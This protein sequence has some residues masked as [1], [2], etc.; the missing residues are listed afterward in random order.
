[1]AD[2]FAYH[3]G[4]A[5]HPAELPHSAGSLFILF[6]HEALKAFFDPSEISRLALARR[7]QRLKEVRRA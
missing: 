2:I 6:A 5:R 4:Y 3:T 1:L 7:W